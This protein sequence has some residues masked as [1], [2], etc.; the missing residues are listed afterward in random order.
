MTPELAK[1][2]NAH[3]SMEVIRDFINWLSGQDI[4]LGT[5]TESG[6]W[7][8]PVGE[9]L[10]TMLSRYFDI[11]TVKLENERRALLAKAGNN[12]HPLADPNM[13]LPPDD[14]TGDPEPLA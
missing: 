10:D 1:F 8:L 13:Q 12:R 4:E 7:M 2:A 5:W 11:D 14:K 6:R 9:G 3:P